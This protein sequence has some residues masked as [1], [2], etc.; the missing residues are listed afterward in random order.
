MADIDVVMEKL[1]S[2][3]TADDLADYF[4]HYGI[5]AEPHAARHCAISK[6]VQEETGI[7]EVVTSSEDISVY[8]V[9]DDGRVSYEKQICAFEHS[10]AMVEF[11]RKF[12]RCDYMD[13]VDTGYLPVE[14]YNCGDPDCMAC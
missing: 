4:K 11:V 8:K 12:D 13:L 2:F 6:F 5:K 10:P 7:K 1:Y 14:E 9:V 3:E